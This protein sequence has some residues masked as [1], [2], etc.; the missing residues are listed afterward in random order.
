MNDPP[1]PGGPSYRRAT[2][3]SAGSWMSVQCARAPTPSV[4]MPTT[5]AS[6]VSMS[7]EIATRTDVADTTT[8]LVSSSASR[9]PLPSSSSYAAGSAMVP[10][11]PDGEPCMFTLATL[12]ARV[13]A[14]ATSATAPSLSDWQAARAAASAAVCMCRR[15]AMR[16]PMSTAIPATPSSTMMPMAMITS[17]WP[18][19]APVG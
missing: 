10:A 19:G 3:G 13:A 2:I 7:P 15:S 18:R 6:I 11:V 8:P 14:A 4:G 5:R 17:T 12:R 1:G 9:K 16:R